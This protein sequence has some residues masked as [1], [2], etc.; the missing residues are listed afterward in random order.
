MLFGPVLAALAIH[1]EAAAPCCRSSRGR[2]GIDLKLR[3]GLNSGEVIA[4]EIGFRLFRLHR[5][6]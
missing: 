5:G 4:G 6:W 1:E 3:V 2:D